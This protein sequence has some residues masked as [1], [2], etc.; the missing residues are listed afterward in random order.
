MPTTSTP[1][2]KCEGDIVTIVCTAHQKRIMDWARDQQNRY[3]CTMIPRWAA[4]PCD[5]YEEAKRQ[6]EKVKNARV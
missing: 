6:Y 1:Y 3:N 4:M 5:N 2:M